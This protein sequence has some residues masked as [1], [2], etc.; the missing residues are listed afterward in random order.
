MQ[1]LTINDLEFVRCQS[2][3]T[4]RVKVMIYIVYVR[5]P[6]AKEQLSTVA[7]PSYRVVLAV[8]PVLIQ[9]LVGKLTKNSVVLVLIKS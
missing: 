1:F 5:F 3:R 7:I 6:S 2:D 4:I 9:Q 8:I